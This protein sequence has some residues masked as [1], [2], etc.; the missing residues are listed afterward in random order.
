MSL[1]QGQ[2]GQV[3]VA[4][5]VAGNL[6]LGRLSDLIASQLHGRWFE[7][8]RFGN[9]FSAMLAANTTTTAAGNIALAAAAAVT[10]FALWNPVGSGVLVSLTKSLLLPIS[11]TLPAGVLTH[12]I[13]QGVPNASVGTK[14]VN[15]LF[16]GSTSKAL[17]VASAAGVALTGSPNALTNLR[18]MPFSFF[19]AAIAAT[20]NLSPG[21]ENI[22]G[23]IVLQPGYGWVPTW[24][25]AGTTLL[26]GFGVSWEEIAI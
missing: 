24:P 16:G 18:P 8:T 10:N 5:G 7:T 22:D 14:A 6:R 21:L 3:V 23:D 1:V 9:M 4:D 2:G 11:G 12:S 26:T 17:Y 20:T 13:M 15:N 19:A 25:A